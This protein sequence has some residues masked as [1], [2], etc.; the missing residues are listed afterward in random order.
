MSLRSWWKT[1]SGTAKTVTVLATMLILQ[2]GVCFGGTSAI[3]SWYEAIFGPTHDSELGLGLTIWQGIFGIV[4]FI[5]LSI[6][7]IVAAAGRNEP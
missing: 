2:I 3:A 5:A 1:S 4:T 6:A 7:L